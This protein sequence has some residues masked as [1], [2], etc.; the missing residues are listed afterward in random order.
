MN[1][2]IT[3]FNR[4]KLFPIIAELELN[5]TLQQDL[6]RHLFEIS[7]LDKL[8]ENLLLDKA[9]LFL[10]LG[11][12]KREAA[13]WG[14]II[15]A[16]TDKD[17]AELQVQN[18]LRICEQWV[19]NPT[20]ELCYQAKVLAEVLDLATACSWIAM[21]IFWSGNNIAAPNKPPV[22]PSEFMSGHAIANGIIMSINKY[23]GNKTEIANNYLRRG[24]HIMMG[25]NG[26][27]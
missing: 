1:Q 9:I 15:A 4:E 8:I 5:I 11:L 26:K 22:E 20:E 16:E 3:K 7:I 14:Y 24:I 2:T 10:A 25:G 12:P 6:L 13:W 23:P 21:A 18:C 17:N 27:I 19:R